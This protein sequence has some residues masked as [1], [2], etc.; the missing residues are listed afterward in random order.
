MQVLL[1][2][3]LLNK[4]HLNNYLQY[5]LLFLDLPGMITKGDISVNL[6]SICGVILLHLPV[7]S[8]FILNS[9]SL[10]LLPFC[11]PIIPL[12]S[13]KSIILAARL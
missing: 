9:T 4:H 5:I 12:S 6:L 7:S 8:L 3:S 11:G 10:G 13:S 2:Q 1:L